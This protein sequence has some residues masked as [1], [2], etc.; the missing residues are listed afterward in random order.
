MD[1]GV[2][3]RA[4]RTKTLASTNYELSVPGRIYKIEFPVT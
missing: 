1:A 4:G 3:V 2:S